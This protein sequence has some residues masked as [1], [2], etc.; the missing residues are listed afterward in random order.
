MAK[1]D[2][3]FIPQNKAPK[4]N[5]YIGV[6][7][8][9]EFVGKVKTGALKMPTLGS[10]MYSFGALSDVHVNTAQA[11]RHFQKALTY[12]NDV[13]KVKFT[14]VAGDITNEG[15]AEQLQAYGDYV[16]TY[17]P[18]TPVYEVTGNHD[19]QSRTS[20]APFDFLMP[21]TGHNLYYSF[22]QGNDVFI[23]FGMSGWYSYT[24]SSIF[25]VASLQWLYETLE[26]N[27]NKR[28]IVFQHCPNFEGS[29]NPY[30]PAP[31][32]D[33]LSTGTGPVFKSLMAHYTNVIWFHGHTHMSFEAQKDCSYA[34]YDRKFGCH[35]VHIPSPVSVK[36][37]NNAGTGYDA[38]TSKGMGYVVDVYENHVV[39]RGRDFVNEKFLPIATYC[40][41]TTLQTIPPNSYTDSTGTITT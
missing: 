16:K 25:S 41:D 21:Y 12:F 40:I 3:K 30:A 17:S 28:C 31:T 38:V 36:V 8:G 13:E 23:M 14:C 35:S 4:N 20:E 32:G 18:N 27:R 1:Y 7:N 10:R 33:L 11:Q 24:Q 19:L 9:T 2:T 22:T 5:D 34:N 29:G 15:T 37:L 26:A 6:Y 39:L